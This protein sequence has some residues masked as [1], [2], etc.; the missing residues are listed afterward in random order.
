MNE[1][2]MLT[3]MVAPSQHREGKPRGGVIQIHVTRACDLGCFNCTQGSNLRG[4]YSF[5]S[6]ENFEKACQSLQTYFG[7]VG[8]FGGNPAIHPQFE[9]L[10]AILRKY[11]P[12]DCCGLWCNHPRGNGRVM[13]RTFNPSVS[14]LNVHMKQEAYDEFLRDWPECKPF[15]LTKDSRHSPPYVAM[16][17]VVL[18]TCPECEGRGGHWNGV[19]SV[20]NDWDCTNC[21]GTGKVTDTNRCRELIA[22][23]DI[24]QHWSAM[25]CEIRGGLYGYFCEIAGAQ[26]ILHQ[27]DIHWPIS[28]VPVDGSSDWWDRPMEDYLDQVRQHCFS[29]GVPLRG[30]GNLAQ[31]TEGQEQVTATHESIYQP[32]N[33]ERLVELVTDI[34]QIDS[35]NLVFTQYVQGADK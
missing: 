8:V 5:I 11:I 22:A 21:Q 28:G 26:A 33:K 16:K 2:Q 27:N 32:K 18:K 10:C 19:G 14:N 29:C 4:P 15:G 23:C 1:D 7:I 3:R 20:R 31:A 9:E 17:D 12:K 25:I 13:R 35:R 6:L 34:N 30:Y 24:N